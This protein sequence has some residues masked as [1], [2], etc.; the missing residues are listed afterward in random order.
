MK[1]YRKN[2]KWVTSGGRDWQSTPPVPV[3]DN[4][5]ENNSPESRKDVGGKPN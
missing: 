5:E 1:E 3:V 2:R 4:T